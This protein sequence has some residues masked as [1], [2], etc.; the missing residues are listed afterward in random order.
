MGP[1]TLAV[2]QVQELWDHV[3]VNPQVYPKY[4]GSLP[5]AWLNCRDDRKHYLLHSNLPNQIRIALEFP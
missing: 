1:K 3:A 2:L 4:N 5:Y